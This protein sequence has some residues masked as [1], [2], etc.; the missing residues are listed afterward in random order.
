MLLFIALALLLI[1]RYQVRYALERDIQLFLGLRTLVE[2]EK[3]QRK[4][5]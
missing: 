4:I 2:R 5:K 3:K 1:F